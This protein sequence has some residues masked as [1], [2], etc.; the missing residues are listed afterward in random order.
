[1]TITNHALTGAVIGLTVSNPLIAIPAAYVSHYICDAIP[2]YD[3]DNDRMSRPGFKYYL[4]ADAALCVALVVLLALVRPDMWIVAAVCAFLATSPDL[5]WIN[6]YRCVL[7]GKAWKPNWHSKFA[8]RIQW[9][10]RPIGAV[11][12]VSWAI[13]ALFVLISQFGL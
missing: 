4:A 5:F 2:H 10:E 8:S 13:A 6:R 7:A 11:V 3:G 1:M 9:F 12:E